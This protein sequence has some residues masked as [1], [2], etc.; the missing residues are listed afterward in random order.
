V[1]VDGQDGRAGMAAIVAEGDLDLDA[2]ER[3]LQAQLPAYARPIFLRITKEIEVTG[4]FKRRKVNLVKEGFDPAAIEDDLY[5]R[6]PTN[7]GFVPLDRPLYAR[8]QSGEVRL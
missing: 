8:I 2:L 1:R 7:G 3:H 5:F 4:T 6:D